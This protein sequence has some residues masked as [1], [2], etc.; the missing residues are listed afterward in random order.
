[1]FAIEQQMDIIAESLG[2]DPVKLRIK[3]ANQKGDITSSG[4][5]VITCNIE[6]CIRRATKAIDWEEKKRSK[7]PNRGLGLSAMTHCTG[8]RGIYAGCDVSGAM[9]K[10]EH[11]GSTTVYVGASETGQ[12]AQTVLSQ[13]AAEQ[14]GLSLDE[15]KVILGDTEV[16]PVD[17][18]NY[19]DRTTAICGH[20]VSIAATDAKKQLLAAASEMLDARV[21]DLDLKQGKVYVKTDPNR[22]VSIKNAAAYSY[23]TKAVPI[24]GKGIYDSKTTL[25]EDWDQFKA[26]PEKSLTGKVVDAP[27]PSLDNT[28]GCQ[29]VEVEVDPET[30]EVKVLEIVSVHDVGRA[31]NPSMSESQVEGSIAQGMGLALY[32][33]LVY[34]DGKILNPS[35]TDYKIMNAVDMPRNV[36]IILVEAGDSEGPY[37]SKGIAEPAI[38]PTAGAIANAVYD[39]VG[40]RIKDTPLTPEKIVKA[41]KERHEK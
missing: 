19:G 6:E 31:L 37:G 34:G 11:D 38:V 24:T 15:V 12:G 32:E 2:I 18:G 23:W 3:N 14:L 33:Q 10:I 29:A 22:T 20:A 5:K 13:I 27:G 25:L 16:T 40:V 26:Y 36:K 35:F 8:W 9:V 17:F 28:F 4:C 7:K 30:G 39:A 1:M 41:L 21:E